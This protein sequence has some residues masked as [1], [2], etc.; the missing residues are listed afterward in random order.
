MRILSVQ[1][2]RF[3]SGLCQQSRQVSEE[4]GGGGS[5]GSSG[6]SAG[7]DAEKALLLYGLFYALGKGPAKAGTVAPQPAKST[8]GL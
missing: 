4:N 2:L 1:V 7:K 3:I 6:K 8:S 5:G